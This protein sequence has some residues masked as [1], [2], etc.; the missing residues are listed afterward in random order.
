MAE[1]NGCNKHMGGYRVAQPSHGKGRMT[2][3]TFA[4]NSLSMGGVNTDL[5]GGAPQKVKTSLGSSH[6]GRANTG[7]SKA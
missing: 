6:K 2:S 7:K 5:G 4:R 1:M 3:T